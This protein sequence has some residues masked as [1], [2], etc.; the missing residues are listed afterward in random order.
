ML[1]GLRAASD[2]PDRSLAWRERP[3]RNRENRL[4]SYALGTTS[5]TYTYGP[6][7]TRFAKSVTLGTNPAQLTTFYR[8]EVEKAADPGCCRRSVS[9]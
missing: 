6:D 3:A 2:L 7:G 5:A 8:A 9:L 4:K 1:A